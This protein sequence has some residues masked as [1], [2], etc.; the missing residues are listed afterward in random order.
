[1]SAKTEEIGGARLRLLYVPTV[2]ILSILVGQIFGLG[3]SLLV[4]AGGALGGGILLIWFSLQNLAGEAPL[5]F[6]EALSLGAPSAEEEQKRAVLRALKD[7]EYE[8]AVGKI[9][10]KDYLSLSA[11][12]RAEAR[13]LLQV[14]DRDLEPER[15]RA[16]EELARR[17]GNLAHDPEEP[18]PEEPA[19]EEAKETVGAEEGEPSSE[20][21]EK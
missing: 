4:V 7:L 8:K 1:M 9:N 2:L 12:Y 5:T 6:E 13:R 18:D 17:L 11:H 21:E 10:D 19:T 3:A 15:K 16:E 20:K 14:L